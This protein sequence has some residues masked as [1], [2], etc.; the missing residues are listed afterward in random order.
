MDTLL[1]ISVPDFLDKLLASLQAYQGLFGK[2]DFIFS[3]EGNIAIDEICSS[4]AI[5]QAA[6]AAATQKQETARKMCYILPRKVLF[7]ANIN[8]IS[9]LAIGLRCIVRQSPLTTKPQFRSINP[10]PAHGLSQA[11]RL[12]GRATND[13]PIGP[14][15]PPLAAD[16]I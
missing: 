2:M 16:I 5:E 8:F 12:R 1:N 11:K 14:Q 10:F 3:R 15:I 4:L 7:P 13:K 6:F 9:S